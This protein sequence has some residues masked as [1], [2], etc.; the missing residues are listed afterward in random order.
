MSN[1]SPK[2]VT[3]IRWVGRSAIADVAGDVDLDC[4]LEFQHQLLEALDKSP[5][6]LIVN[7]RGVAY[8]DSSGVASLV[9]MLSKARKLHC[10]LVLAEMQQRVQ[11]VFEMTRLDDVFTIR[12]TEKEALA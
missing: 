11:S 4:S 5:A 2:P 10:Q 6:R 9:K 12:A 7:L 8:M 3:G 1:N